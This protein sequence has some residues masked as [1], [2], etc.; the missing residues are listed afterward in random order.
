[1]ATI[2][3]K[4][5]VA[6]HLKEGIKAIAQFAGHAPRVTKTE[7]D[8]ASQLSVS[9]RALQSWKYSSSIPKTIDDSQLL[10]L[11]WLV[12]TKGNLDLRWMIGLLEAT[13]VVVVS[14]PSRGWVRACLRG[15]RL[16]ARAP[17]EVDI[18]RVVERFFGKAEQKAHK[19]QPPFLAPPRPY[20]QLIGRE[21]LFNQLKKSLM[22][23]DNV[24]LFALNGLPGVGKTA[25]AIRLAHDSEIRQHFPDGILWAGL[26]C[27]P[28]VLALLSAWGAALSIPA[29]E[30]AGFSDVMSR[31]QAFLRA[32]STRRMLLVV[33]DAW[34][35]GLA[36]AFRVGGP[37]CA[38]LVTTREPTVALDIAGR[39]YT[40]TVP[41]LNQEH[42]SQLLK[43]FAY[44]VVTKEESAARSLVQTVGGLP[45]AL[46]LMGK[47]LQVPSSRRNPRRIR[48]ALNELQ[49]SENRFK[50]IE[51]Q[52]T[53]LSNPSLG[54]GVSL[55]LLSC[56]G[57]SAE[58]LDEEARRA[59]YALSVFP[60]KPNTFNEEAALAVCA[61]SP[62][63]LD[64][65]SDA[66]LLEN[67]G[68]TRYTLHQTIADY[69]LITS[70]AKAR[71][72]AACRMV[73]FF[74]NLVTTHQREYMVLD[75]ELDNIL[76]ALSF[77][78]ESDMKAALLAGANASFSFFEVRGLYQQAERHLR[79]AE[80]AA[81]DINQ[82]DGLV[83]VL[84]N[85]GHL[86]NKQGPSSLAQK[87]YQEALNLARR[88][89]NELQIGSLLTSLGALAYRRADYEQAKAYYN[90]GMDVAQQAGDE[91]RIV[92]L[93]TNLG[94]V[95]VG[96]GFYK[97]AGKHY[98]QALQLAVS[99]DLEKRTL[100]IL[101]Q[102]LGDL[103]LKRGNYEQAKKYCQEGLAVACQTGD[104]ELRSRL[105][106]NLGVAICQQ[107]EYF[108]ATR[109]FNKALELAE[110]SHLP[111]EILR[112]LANLGMVATCQ[113]DYC[114]AN[115]YYQ[116]AM[117]LARENRYLP[118]T[119]IILNK[120][121][122]CYLAQKKW[123]EANKTFAEAQQIAK[124]A[125]HYLLLAESSYGLARIAAEHDNFK[126]AHRIGHES[127][128]ILAT[129]DHKLKHDVMQWLETLPS[130]E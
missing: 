109:L 108:E 57:V 19:S 66:G 107:G 18:E 3:Q 15:A 29:D 45:L 40:Y 82:I 48:R 94:L 51:K 99:L 123:N 87:L 70:T 58:S 115:S 111:R 116:D 129:T 1:M 7:G 34:E 75:K 68:L 85:L 71:Q 17:A 84:S 10:A 2:E 110:V 52:S 104:P 50:L 127:L 31:S 93:L 27:E 126:E 105:L 76:T 79:R 128:S 41:E 53:R 42:G 35:S 119:C 46:I 32:I 54:R 89:E 36:A 44:E 61:A 16:N 80:Q 55:S 12:L 8:I 106:G 38:Y 59:L 73:N 47:Y 22:S 102:N 9:V 77:A 23:D 96:E 43:Q 92:A 33:D 95:A 20:Y 28:D 90:Q 91:S 25:L 101:H 97:Q 120:Q 26:G 103:M 86:A 113:E 124:N 21:K 6:R 60:P 5:I 78:H 13:S 56:I 39:A 112:Q 72:K 81:R 11:V 98:Q 100:I 63:A 24:G 62:V 74:V 88:T 69:A 67:S 49:Q 125:Q 83:L 14:P 118:D 114:C 64:T 117:K 130:I 30:M 122:F 4:E 121:G 65:L 37:N